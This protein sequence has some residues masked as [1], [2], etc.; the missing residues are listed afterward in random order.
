MLAWWLPVLWAALFFGRQLV[1]E[2][3][4]Y[5]YLRFWQFQAQEGVAVDQLS[6]EAIFKDRS[7]DDNYSSVLAP[8]S[9][10]SFL[11]L[12]VR[13]GAPSS[14]LAPIIVYRSVVFVCF[15][16]VLAVIFFDL[17]GTWRRKQTRQSRCAVCGA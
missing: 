4:K 6:L 17:N 2:I 15:V 12:V 1:C 10:N 5:D 13:P 3:C 8:S 16:L 11:F 14:V 9:D 7:H